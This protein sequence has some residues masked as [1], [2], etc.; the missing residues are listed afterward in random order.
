MKNIYILILLTISLV[1]CSTSENKKANLIV[2]GQVKG[3]R[4]GNLLIKQMLNDSL[5]SI[6]SIKVDGEEHFEFHTNI[7]EPQMMLLEL[8]EVKDDKILF[9]AAPQDTIKIFA[10]VESFGINPRI[11]GGINQ[12]QLNTFNQM[13]KQFNNK[14]MDLFKAEFDAR[15]NYLLKEADSLK[16]ALERLQHKRQLYTLN[17]I[18]QNKNHAIAPYI[19]MMNF[20]DNPKALDTIYKVLPE[21]QKKS[22]YAK[23]IKKILVHN[24]S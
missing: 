16:K 4:L 11:K 9:F 1:S 6:D 23:E 18:F 3:L 20:Y 13:I 21:A 17:F 2:K 19:A 14:E 8:P 15:K 24:P 22:I 5:V 12:Q 10:Y 7:D